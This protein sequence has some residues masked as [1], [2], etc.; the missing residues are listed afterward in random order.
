MEGS[1]QLAYWALIFTLLE[2]S[3]GCS[4]TQQP[5]VTA[6]RPNPVISQSPVSFLKADPSKHHAVTDKSA[7]S[8]EPSAGELNA[9]DY[10]DRGFHKL[11]NKEPKKAIQYFNQAIQTNPQDTNAY[12]YRGLARTDLGDKQQ[13]IVDYTKVIHIESKSKLTYLTTLAYLNRGDVRVSLGN[14][15]QAIQDYHKAADL[16]QKQGETSSYQKVLHKIKAIQ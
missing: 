2:L 11:L 6:S 7:E 10:F 3:N 16:Y 15:Q 13:A 9:D 12:Y 4:L 14:K 1:R 5:Q 8:P